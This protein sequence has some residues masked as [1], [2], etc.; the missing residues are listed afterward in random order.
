MTVCQTYSARIPAA[1]AGISAGQAR[2][3][4]PD[5][6][7]APAGLDADLVQHLRG[8]S[9]CSNDVLW[10][11]DIRDEVDVGTYPCLHLA[12]GAGSAANGVVQRQNNL[13]LIGGIVIGYC[14]WCALELNV[15]A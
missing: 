4:V 6:S 11:F 1:F 3:A 12:Y 2:A 8:C 5:W 14:P 13:Y 9:D 10:F 7:P 15:S